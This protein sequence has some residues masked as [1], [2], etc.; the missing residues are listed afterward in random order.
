MTQSSTP[1]QV[2][3]MPTDL[4][5]LKFLAGYWGA[6]D[7]A[8]ISTSEILLDPRVRMKCLVPRCYMSGACS[9]CPPNGS[10]LEEM[11]DLVSRH[12]AAVFFRVKV[13]SRIIAAKGLARYINSGRLDHTGNLFNLGAHYLLIFSIVK[14]LQKTVREMGYESGGGFAAGNCRD[15]LCHFQPNCQ[16]LSKKICRH[17]DLSSPSMESCGMNAFAMA[18]HQGW[19]V[20]PIGGTCE[21][22]SVATGNL[23]GLVLIGRSVRK[24]VRAGGRDETSEPV[25]ESD[26]HPVRGL[27]RLSKRLSDNMAAMRKAD[28]GLFLVPAMIRQRKVWWRLQKN[29]RDLTGSWP[30]VLAMNGRLFE[31]HPGKKEQD[32]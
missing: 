7:A 15:A 3:I 2:E 24:R 27:Q 14:L 25:R 18:A 12:A 1:P 26:R 29:L 23:M 13:Q 8:I 31:G 22:E 16:H 11:E 19:D 20:Y 5:E 10:S 4:E 17:P 28:A 30:G 6:N 21:P 9:H 32:G